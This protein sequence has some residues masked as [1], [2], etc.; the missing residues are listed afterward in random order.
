MKQ[1]HF[2]DFCE[3]LGVVSEQYGKPISEGAKILYWQGLADFEFPAVQQALFRHVRNPDNGMF[4]PKVAD[5]VRMLQGSTQDSALNAWAKV[6]KAVRQV[7]TGSTVVFDDPIIHRVLQDMGGWLGLGQRSED[8]WPFV[9]KEFENR[10]RGF[11]AR[12]EKPDYPKTLV[13]I[14]DAHNLPNGFKATQPVL[15]GNRQLAEQVML[16]G[17]DKPALEFNSVAQ[18]MIGTNALAA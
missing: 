7:G 8:E 12:G 6:D 2:D 16:G 3:L 5:I 14:Y 4:M 15:I 11:K 17:T 13:G 1:E 9:A 10:Y 18:S